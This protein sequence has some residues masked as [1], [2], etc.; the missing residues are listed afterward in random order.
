MTLNEVNTAAETIYEVVDPN[1]NIIFGAVI[2]DKMQG[3]MRITVIATGFTGEIA[4]PATRGARGSNTT[5]RPAA[6]PQIRKPSGT[7]GG[8]NDSFPKPQPPQNVGADL[9]AFLQ[10]RRPK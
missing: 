2:D 8:N 7:P 6:E 5:Q 1:A 4:E 9:P 10:N 3:E